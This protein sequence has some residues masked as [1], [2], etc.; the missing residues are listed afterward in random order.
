MR[1]QLPE[2]VSGLSAV[3]AKGILPEIGSAWAQS[4]IRFTQ[5][6]LDA[7][8]AEWDTAVENLVR[9]NEALRRFCSYA[10][11]CAGEDG[12]NADLSM[13]AATLRGASRAPAE[14][15]LHISVLSQ[16]NDELWR[17]VEPLLALLGRDGERDDLQNVQQALQP[18]LR[19]YVEVR[20]FHPI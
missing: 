15:S 18:V 13:H 7:M 10:A 11:S 12:N 6:L 14:T 3:L 8:A 17:A 1:P 9:E 2:I 19:R 4:Q 5:M 20:R 16:Q